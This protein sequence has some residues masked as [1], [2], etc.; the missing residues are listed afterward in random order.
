MLKISLLFKNFTNFTGKKLENS[1]DLEGEIFRLLFLYEHKQT[2]REIFKSALVYLL[3]KIW[4][5]Q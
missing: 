1:L 5:L 3:V 2:Y 4:S